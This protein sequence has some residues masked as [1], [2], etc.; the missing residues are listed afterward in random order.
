M[1]TTYR[2]TNQKQLRREFWETF[3]ELKRR[4]DTNHGKIWPA[5]TRMAFVDWIDSLCKGGEI[6]SALAQ[7]AT[8]P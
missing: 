3:P 8:L 7:R 1:A 5:D 6:S 4:L 2:I